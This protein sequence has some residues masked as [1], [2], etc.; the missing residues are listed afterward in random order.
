MDS[1]VHRPFVAVPIVNRRLKTR[2]EE[3]REAKINY[4]KFWEEERQRYYS[5][6]LQNQTSSYKQNDA[7]LMRVKYLLNDAECSACEVGSFYLFKYSMCV[8][9]YC[10]LAYLRFM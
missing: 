8:G 2:I 5:K 1:L 10:R 3:F 4:V 7:R 9:D 6:W